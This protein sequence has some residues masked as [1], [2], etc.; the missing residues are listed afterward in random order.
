MAQY[1]VFTNNSNDIMTSNTNPDVHIPTLFIGLGGTG[2]DILL[3]FREKLFARHGK[4]Y[5][6]KLPIDFLYYD[7]DQNC[8][9]FDNRGIYNKE[10][11]KENIAFK[12]DEELLAKPD[13][14]KAFD[15][16]NEKTYS[17]IKEWLS[18]GVQRMDTS[19]GSGQQRQNARLAFFCEYEKIIEV[20][21]TKFH[22][23]E[24]FQNSSKNDF[25]PIKIV[26][27]FSI[28]GGTGSGTF[29]DM[30]FLCRYL[31]KNFL[32]KTHV[33]FTAHV[34]LPD[35]FNKIPVN[36][37]FINANGYAALKE[38][39]HF[40]SGGK[41]FDAQW[42]YDERIKINTPVFNECYILSGN[43]FNSVP[44]K[45]YSEVFEMA[46]DY[47]D[48]EV[49]V[50]SKFLPFLKSFKSNVSDYLNNFIYS[51]LIQNDDTS[52]PKMFFVDSDFFTCKYS[53]YGIKLIESQVA[54]EKNTSSN[55]QDIFKLS[56][57]SIKPY[58]GYLSTLENS[59]SKENVNH[60]KFVIAN[61][62]NSELAS[63]ANEYKNNLIIDN[64]GNNSMIF[65]SILHGF[66]LF[67]CDTVQN[68]LKKAYDK[69]NMTCCH[70]KPLH[71]FKNNKF[72]KDLIPIFTKN[73]A[74]EYL[75]KLA[76]SVY[77]HMLGVTKY[78]P[79]NDQ[80][81]F[82]YTPFIGKP[83]LKSK[84]NSGNGLNS[85]L[86]NTI[87]SNG[88]RIKIKDFLRERCFGDNKIFASIIR[89][90]EISPA[91]ISLNDRGKVKLLK[92]LIFLEAIQNKEIEKIT[93][94]NPSH[95]INPK[96]ESIGSIIGYISTQEQVKL[97][98]GKTNN[99]NKPV[100]L[101]N[102]DL[103]DEFNTKYPFD[104]D[105]NWDEAFKTYQQVFEV[106]GGNKIRIKFT[107]EDLNLS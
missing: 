94:A 16:I 50:Q 69:I 83:P 23:L 27:V 86:E 61:S 92:A 2:K 103:I 8:C 58:S 102:L 77:S 48:C 101:I 70:E 41:Y 107:E 98:Y 31:S 11:F 47:L 38:M 67:Y 74:R 13:V 65:C 78:I 9:Q 99:F 45:S 68:E 66:P 44:F 96:S 15:F 100:P 22:R 62:D 26:F 29:I 5:L 34:I 104:P 35:V 71:I 12:K 60:C 19:I 82:N 21:K 4:D 75:E 42:K 17:H 37:D 49:N 73:E 87:E 43:R 80:F 24:N 105:N 55:F 89:S 64:K 72:L 52:S 39:E 14:N 81:E 97:L 90:D 57:V 7:L 10:E 93:K 36:K 91:M 28:A 1:D 76:I 51:D 33:D 88:K 106:T 84:I 54:S 20:L 6:T 79:E 53:S 18:P 56:D 59:I 46:A 85:D 30:A 32:T 63:L 40:M 95:F 3:R 25:K